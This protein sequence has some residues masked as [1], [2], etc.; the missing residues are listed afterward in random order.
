MNRFV[1]AVIL[2]ATCASCDPIYGLVHSAPNISRI[3][4]DS[5][6]VNAVEAIPGMTNVS[7]RIDVGD[8][9]LT[10]HGVETAA[11]IHRFFYTYNGI[12]GNFYLQVSY[13]GKG[14]YDHAFVTMGKA[15]PQAV[16]DRIHPALGQIESALEMKCGVVNLTSAVK[17]RCFGVRCSGI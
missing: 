2:C 3:P 14:T 13:D 17:E 4:Q 12:N 8:R 9:P 1:F 10:L 16:I 6:V 15:P 5:C 7:S 11:Q